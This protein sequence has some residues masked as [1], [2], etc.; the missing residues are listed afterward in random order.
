VSQRLELLPAEQATLTATAEMREAQRIAVEESKA[1]WLS[2]LPDGRP[3]TSQKGGGKG[4]NPGKEDGR[5]GGD[6]RKGG[7]ASGGKGDWKRREDAGGA[8]T[9]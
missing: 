4:K 9:G 8:K 1:R 7:K 5:K 2:S 3:Q 6:T